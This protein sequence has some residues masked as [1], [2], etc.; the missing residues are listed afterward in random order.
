MDKNS[1]LKILYN[2]LDDY[3]SKEYET[4]F[5]W[6]DHRERITLKAMRKIQK[7]EKEKN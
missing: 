6:D 4:G 1:R 2:L 7:L 5:G 3:D